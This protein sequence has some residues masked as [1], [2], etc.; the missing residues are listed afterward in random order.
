MPDWVFARLTPAELVEA[1]A[2]WVAAGVSLVGGCCGITPEHI[3]ALV[4]AA[5]GWSGEG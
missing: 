1:A 3:A 5:P 2:G 4:A